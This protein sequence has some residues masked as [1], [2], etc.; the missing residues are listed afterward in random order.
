MRKERGGLGPP[1]ALLLRI[2]APY[3]RAYNEHAAFPG[4]STAGHQ[5]LE[6]SIGVRIPAREFGLTTETRS[7]TGLI[8]R[9][10]A[11]EIRTRFVGTP[12]RRQPCCLPTTKQ[13]PHRL[14]FYIRF[15]P[16]RL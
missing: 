8:S 7:R 11:K 2:D 4:R 6:L 12:G 1:Y 16:L 9:E 14:P 3:R 10:D 15:A 13:L 5:P